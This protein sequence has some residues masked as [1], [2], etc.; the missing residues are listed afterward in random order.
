MDSSHELSSSQESSKRKRK[1][2][3]LTTGK[4]FRH[5]LSAEK[6]EDSSAALSFSSSQES[7]TQVTP[8]KVKATGNQTLL[9]ST[10]TS[11]TSTADSISEHISV[12]TVEDN[13]LSQCKKLPPGIK[14]LI[15]NGTFSQLCETLSE[16]GQLSDFSHLLQSIADGKVPAENLCWLLNIHLGKLMS[17]DS[18]MQMRWHKDLIE[19]FS[20]VYILFGA[21]AINV[22]HVDQCILV[23]SSWKMLR[24]GNL[25]RQTLE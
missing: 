14:E 4:K 5:H 9:A 3:H 13:L 18:T 21:S 7:S 1:R 15:S 6:I 19:F 2:T 20:I 12:Q 24:K 8:L 17:L 10:C 25:T 16:K 23:I 11:S 22:L